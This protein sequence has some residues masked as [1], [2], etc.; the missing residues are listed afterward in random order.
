MRRLGAV[1]LLISGMIAMAVSLSRLAAA[2]PTAFVQ[3]APIE[4]RTFTRTLTAY[5]ATQPDS[6]SVMSINVP[7]AGVIS[8]VWVRVGQ[9]VEEGARLL[10]LDTSPMASMQ[11][12]QAQAAV[13]YARNRLKREEE[14]FHTQ[15]TTQDQVA[16]AR[17]NL[18]D[19]EAQLEAQRKLG[20]GQ[21]TEILK[22][23]FG[24][25]VI[26][27]NVNQGD[28]IQAGTNA[29]LLA[30]QDSLVVLLGLE[31]E[32]ASNV[33]Q[34]M[35]VLLSPV[36][37]P[38]ITFSSQVSEVH[39]MINPTTRL[40]DVL[41]RVQLPAKTSFPLGLT[42][43]G[44]IT[45]SRTE[46]LGVP[47]TA[48]MSG[49]DGTWIFVARGGR[50]YKVPVKTGLQEADWVAISGPISQGDEAV[51]LGNYELEDGMLIRKGIP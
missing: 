44:L 48:I 13:E 38:S 19:A 15:L 34:G 12:Q 20:A 10:D 42:M 4:K 24:G 28:L 31:P 17:K 6:A 39:A 1:Y 18:A 35:P 37:E 32:E 3:T 43:K 26:G 22:A 30:R 27:L 51:V 36:F 14:L 40:V 16:S 21:P 23:P 46:S 25:V 11:Y 49:K 5:G 29:L 2:E 41:V 33:R 7:R 50:A 9:L 8:R 45:L 47:R